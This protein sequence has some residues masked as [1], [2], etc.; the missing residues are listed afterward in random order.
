MDSFRK[1]L[2]IYPATFT[3]AEH[4]QTFLWYHLRA[5]PGARTANLKEIQKYFRRADKVVP[6]IDSLRTAFTGKE[7]RYYPQGTKKDNFGID[8]RHMSWWNGNFGSC[9]DEVEV[10]PGPD[11]KI[12]LFRKDHPLW[13]WLAAVGSLASIVGIPLAILLWWHGNA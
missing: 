1:L 13:F 5:N 10:L 9:F 11:R 3:E 4:A 2:E 12:K 8:P 6:S 7:S